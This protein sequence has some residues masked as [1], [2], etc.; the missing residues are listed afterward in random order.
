VL[1]WFHLSMR[2]QHFAQAAK[3]WPD[4]TANDRQSGA[5]LVETIERI[6]WR[7]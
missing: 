1:D 7:L 5:T 2:I 3:G 6:R 4:T